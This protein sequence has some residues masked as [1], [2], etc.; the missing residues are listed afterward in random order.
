MKGN[1]KVVVYKEF[2]LHT[3]VF[4]SFTILSNFVTATRQRGHFES[5][6]ACINSSTSSLSAGQTL[7]K[8]QICDG[9]IS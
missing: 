7:I 1:N 4:L 6:L 3:F 8:G 5:D 2:F 9:S